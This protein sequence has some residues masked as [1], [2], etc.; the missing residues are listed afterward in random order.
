MTT[1][2]ATFQAGEARWRVHAFGALGRLLRQLARALG[3]FN[4]LEWRAAVLQ[5]LN[6]L[7]SLGPPRIRDLA[8]PDL[9]HGPGREDFFLGIALL[10]SGWRTIFNRSEDAPR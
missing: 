4:H 6:R 10:L 5:Y 2:I 8:R 3:N 1:P 9:A 7:Q